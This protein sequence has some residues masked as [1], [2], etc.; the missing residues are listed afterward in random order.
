M[1]AARDAAA[2]RIQRQNAKMAAARRQARASEAAAE[3]RTARWVE[4]ARR[5]AD[6]ERLQLEA[7]A[8]LAASLI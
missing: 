4:A 5:R 1:K 7:A 2:A 3:A 8:Q 6:A